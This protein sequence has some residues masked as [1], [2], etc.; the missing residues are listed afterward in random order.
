L[1]FSASLHHD[2]YHCREAIRFFGREIVDFRKILIELE[3]LPFVVL[4]R[5]ARRMIGDR[6]PAALPEAAMA[7]HLEILRR[8]L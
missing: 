8:S 4:E 1:C 5:R 6:L 3:Q 2:F 7:E